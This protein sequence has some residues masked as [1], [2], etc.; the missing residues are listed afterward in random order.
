MATAAEEQEAEIIAQAR[1]YGILHLGE[2]FR[3]DNA[4]RGIFGKRG[5]K[6]TALE[7]VWVVLG[8]VL[9]LIF[10]FFVAVTLGRFLPFFQLVLVPFWAFLPAVLGLRL[11]NESPLRKKTGEGTGVWLSVKFKAV[12]VWLSSLP[13][14]PESMRAMRNQCW[15]D[16][17][18]KPGVVECVEWI[19]TTRA[20]RM[21]YRHNPHRDFEDDDYVPVL[22]YDRGDARAKQVISERGRERSVRR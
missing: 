8:Y 1:Q 22:F 20:P 18:K 2:T 5:P 15:S 16:V 14:F 13:I 17:G 4:R 11:A 12:I 9:G 19:G 3:F 7:M 6:L 10:F 21:P